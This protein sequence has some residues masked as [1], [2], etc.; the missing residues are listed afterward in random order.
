[1][2]L[3]NGG[4]HH[5]MY[6]RPHRTQRNR[7]VEFV[8][9]LAT[10]AGTSIFSALDVPSSQALR[11]RLNM[12]AFWLSGLQLSSALSR[13]QV[14]VCTWENC[15]YRELTVLI[16]F[17]YGGKHLWTLVSTRVP[18]PAL[19][20][21]LRGDCIQKSFQVSSLQV[22]SMGLFGLCKY[23]SQYFIMKLMSY[24]CMCTLFPYCS[25]SLKILIHLKIWRKYYVI[26][27]DQNMNSSKH[28]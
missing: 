24:I 8:L 7:K 19:Y 10:G 12:L 2:F 26:N 13:V 25:I 15:R 5:S 16:H 22:G 28:K 4:G 27:I 17:I 1:M 6:Q 21:V 9:C 3:P 20:R 23:I 11:S 18:E 14:R